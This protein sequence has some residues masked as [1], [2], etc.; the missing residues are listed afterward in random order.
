MHG[1]LPIH[2]DPVSLAKNHGMTPV[3]L[4]EAFS[5]VEQNETIIMENWNGFSAGR[6]MN[7][8]W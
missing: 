4:S 6:Y 1:W 8:W 5:L 3:E 7:L 2:A